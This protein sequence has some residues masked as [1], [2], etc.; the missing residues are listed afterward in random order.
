MLCKIRDRQIGERTTKKPIITFYIQNKF[1]GKIADDG[2]QYLTF[3]T[4]SAAIRWLEHFGYNPK[5]FRIGRIVEW[6]NWTWW[7]IGQIL[8]CWTASQPSTDAFPLDSAIVRE[9]KQNLKNAEWIVSQI[10][11]RQVQRGVHLKYLCIALTPQ[12]ASW[13]RVAFM[14]G[15]SDGGESCGTDRGER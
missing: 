2:K 11:P 8:Q 13:E 14:I 1:S 10:R 12:E 15:Y 4:S 3:S 6:T 5:C 7:T 9:L